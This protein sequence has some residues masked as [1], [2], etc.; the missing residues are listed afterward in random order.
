MSPPGFTIVVRPSSIPGGRIVQFSGRTDSANYALA[1][2]ALELEIQ[3]AENVV[4][5]DL[6]RLICIHDFGYSGS[7]DSPHGIKGWGV[8]FL[9]VMLREKLPGRWF[10][11][12]GLSGNM[13]TLWEMLTIEKSFPTFESVGEAEAFW[14]RQR[15]KAT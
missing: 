9:D 12:C 11:Y 14:R 5:F 4:I 10:A 13:R 7:T 1:L 3:P 6:Q 2:K 8:P 15:G